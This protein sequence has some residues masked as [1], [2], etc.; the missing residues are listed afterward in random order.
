MQIPARSTLAGGLTGLAVWLIS[1][2]L[3]HY[4]IQV[5]QDNVGGAVA[6]FSALAVHLVPDS[7]QDKAR[8]LD[9]E[10]KDLAAWLPTIKSGPKD[11]PDS[12]K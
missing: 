9:V 6:L 11:Y 4:G 8:A 5:P 12:K 3:A 7:I 2:L 10:V 1:L